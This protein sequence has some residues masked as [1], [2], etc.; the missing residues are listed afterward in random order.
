MALQMLS[1]LPD[2]AID[3][4][5]AMVV[6]MEVVTAGAMDPDPADIEREASLYIYKRASYE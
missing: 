6:A 3:Q 1:E 5:Q 2:K 4:V